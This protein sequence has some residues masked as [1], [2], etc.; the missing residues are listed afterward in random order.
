MR[1]K[2]KPSTRSLQISGNVSSELACRRALRSWLSRRGVETLVPWLKAVSVE[3][4]L[5]F[6][7]AA[8]R[9]QRT[10]WGSCSRRKNINLNAKLLFLRP[11]LV[12]YLFIHELSHLVHM[13][14]SP[15]Y[16]N[17]V[18]AKHPDY[19]PLDREMRTAMRLVPRW[20]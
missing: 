7:D 14:H 8:V 10:R 16:W 11:E 18:A 5:P 9:L 13:N 15:R 19:E 2:K 4:Q 3:I 6:A 12:R 20:V 17:F 1:N